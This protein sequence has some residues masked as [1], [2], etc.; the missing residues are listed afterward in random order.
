MDVP[1]LFIHSPT[2]GHLGCFQVLAI[3]NKGAISIC[4]E[5]LCGPDFSVYLGKYQRVQLVDHMLRV[6]LV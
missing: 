4:V 5:F 3:M 2:E 6:C 1:Q